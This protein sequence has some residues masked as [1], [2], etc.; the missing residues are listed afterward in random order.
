MLLL[1]QV[2]RLQKLKEAAQR[3]EEERLAAQREAEAAERRRQEEQQAAQQR[4]QRH[5]EEEVGGGADRW[6]L[7]RGVGIDAPLMLNLPPTPPC[8]HYPSS[9]CL[10]LHGRRCKPWQGTRVD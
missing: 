9:G 4:E 5:K 10:P 1:L 8:P 2:E 3:A 6:L 7:C